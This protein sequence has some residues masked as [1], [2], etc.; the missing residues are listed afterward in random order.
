MMTEKEVTYRGD[1]GSSAGVR[2]VRVPHGA[3]GTF[4]GWFSFARGTMITRRMALRVLLSGPVRSRIE[5]WQSDDPESLAKRDNPEPR[6]RP[7]ADVHE[8]GGT[9]KGVKREN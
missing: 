8:S 7:F 5:T 6:R 3:A 9:F 2:S 4:S 1:F